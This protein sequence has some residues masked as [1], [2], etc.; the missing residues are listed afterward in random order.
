M[1]QNGVF[2]DPEVRPLEVVKIPDTTLHRMKELSVDGPWRAPFSLIP[3][4]RSVAPPATR[5]SSVATSTV[6]SG[7][8]K[9]VATSSH[10]S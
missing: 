7:K 9:S 2:T 1:S 4:P 10:L 3:K 8:G 6:V 5:S